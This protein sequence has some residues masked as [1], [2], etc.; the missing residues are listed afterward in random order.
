[1]DD[2][3]G[4]E[5]IIANVFNWIS[6]SPLWPNSLLIITYDEH[7]G[8]YDSVKPGTTVVPN[9]SDLAG[10]NGFVFNQL[11]VRVPAVIVSPMVTAGVDSTI[12]DHSSVPATVER[13]FGL[14]AMTARDAEAN[15]FTHLLSSGVVRTERPSNLNAGRPTPPRKPMTAEDLTAR[16]LEPIPESG[17]LLGFLAVAQKTEIEMSAGSPPE[18]AAI[19]AKVQALKTRGDAEAYINEVMAKVKALQVAH[20]DAVRAAVNK[21]SPKK[22][23]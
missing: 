4:G 11:G 1:M 3:S 19:V 8:F 13:L 23:R 12:Y 6:Q 18:R 14:Q 9:G 5:N 20:A 2:V 22:R 10:A 17:N 21:E 15:D 16:A 7:G